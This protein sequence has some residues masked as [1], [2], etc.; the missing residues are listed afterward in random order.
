MLVCLAFVAMDLLT[1]DGRIPWGA[2]F[3]GLCFLVFVF[4]ARL[5]KFHDKRLKAL[6]EFVECDE[7][8]IRRVIPSQIEETIRWKDIAEIAIVTSDKGPFED[9]VH[10]LISNQDKSTGV[11]FSNGAN[12]IE[13]VLTQLQTLPNFDNQMV[14]TA[15]GST[16]N[17]T[18]VVWKK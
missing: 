13:E 11:G 18:F 5:E 15:M 7:E 10:W 2:M 14:V 9:D 6:C 12:G 17:Q 3:F 8:R 4:S 16:S 1:M